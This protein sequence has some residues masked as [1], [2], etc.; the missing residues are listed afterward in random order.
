MKLTAKRDIN[1]KWLWVALGVLVA[2][3]LY[4]VRE[5]F[6][7]FAI[8]ILLFAALGSVIAGLYMFQ[9]VW[10]TGVLRFVRSQNSWVLALKRA[11]NHAEELARRPLR[12]PGSAATNA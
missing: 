4:F 6:A 1:R 3:Q 11:A 9:K 7:A 10:E 5:L 8:F 12:R 2:S